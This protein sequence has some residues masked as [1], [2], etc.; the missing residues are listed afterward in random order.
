VH[1]DRSPVV[2]TRR[3]DIK[4]KCFRSKDS[5]AV[6]DSTAT[7]LTIG[8]GTLPVADFV[9]LLKDAK[10]ERLVDVRTIP[11]SRH[12]PQFVRETLD[13]SL[14][15]SGLAYFWEPRL[16]GLRGK[17]KDP[18][19]DVALRN[20]SFRNYAAYMRTKP[21]REALSELLA[22]SAR[23]RIA[24]MCSESVWWRCHRRLIADHVTLIEALPVLHLMHNAR[25]LPHRATDGVRVAGSDLIYD[26]LGGQEPLSF[27]T[28]N[29]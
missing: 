21:F 23:L 3:G 4:P 11:K 2:S 8:H 9:A 5:L 15:Q 24:I 7:L 26:V 19:P 1:E 14:V 27:V 28:P 6:K 12:N 13:E 25:L 16:G 29:S 10:I 18:S 22:D 20:D 17:P